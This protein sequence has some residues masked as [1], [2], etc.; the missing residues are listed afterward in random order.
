M[1]V[2]EV[3]WEVSADG[4]SVTPNVPQECGIQGEH[5]ATK[6]VFRIAEGSPFA[7]SQYRLYLSCIDAAGAYDKSPVLTPAGGQV[8]FDLPRAWTQLGGTNELTLTA[9]ADGEIVHTV[10][11]WAVYR[12]RQGATKQENTL[13]AGFMQKAVDAANESREVAEDAAATAV[14]AREA[15]ER[16]KNA[17]F[18]ESKAAMKLVDMYSGDAVP[19]AICS[20]QEAEEGLERGSIPNESLFFLLDSMETL[21]TVNDETELEQKIIDTFATIGPFES[22]RFQ[23]CAMDLSGITC[24]GVVWVAE[25]LRTDLEK[26]WMK[27]VPVSG[28]QPQTIYKRCLDGEW[29]PVE[30]QAPE[31]KVGVEYRTTERWDGKPVYCKRVQHKCEGT[32]GIVGEYKEDGSEVSI[33]VAP[34]AMRLVRCSVN[35]NYDSV[36]P[37]VASNG[38]VTAVRW[39]KDGKLTLR[40][41]NSSW[42]SPLFTADVYYTKS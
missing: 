30:W 1:S 16:A 14:N 37:Y 17:C 40:I 22:V 9:E 3:V 23:F 36:L 2:R 4:M 10:K 39:M 20:M 32:V 21:G 11:V 29:S 28:A 15:A 26:W 42:D 18:N 41:V 7:D 33:S 31:L 25:I 35:A 6:A 27:A 13:L 12:N 24:N 34:D 5:N 8:S 38:G 19:V